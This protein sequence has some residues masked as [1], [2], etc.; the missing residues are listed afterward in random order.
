MSA[1]PGLVVTAPGSASISHQA[2]G[3]LIVREVTLRDFRSYPRLELALEPGVVLVSGLNG[4]G[5]TNLL[6]A[7]HVGT[8][9]FSPRSR[10]D[11]QLVR[12]DAS[13]GRVRLQGVNGET[14]FEAE[15]SLGPR[16]A[17]RARLN[18][19][20]LRSAEQLRHELQA[21]VFTPDRLA[22]VKGAPA[23]RRAYL[24]RTLGRF[25][26]ARAALPVEYAAAVGQRN[27]ALRRLAAGASSADA[28]PPW[29]ETVASLGA[30][31]VTARE[32][33]ITLLAPT[34]SRCADS[35]G[36]MGATL[37]YEGEPVTVSEYEQRL[38]RDLERGLTGAGPHLHEV[39]LEADGR[40]LRSYG[41]QGEQRIAVLALVLAEAETLTERS[42][43]RPLVL[44]DD[45]LSELDGDRRLALAALVS[46]AGQTVL[47]S[48][49]IAAY[50]MEPS[51]SLLVSPGEVRSAS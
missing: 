3:G 13:A 5:K 41:S 36:V 37:S 30:E 46:G 29:T 33:A 21:L 32:K 39:R 43:I 45:V 22:V 28:L 10:S 16:E 4:A 11:A 35:L 51:Q 23:V 7:L 18:G 24:D 12:F 25:F 49:A 8:Q 1:S 40:D 50:P 48:T 17:R 19:S 6:E 26:P 42:G 15:V 20:A 47:T 27:A 14:R 31:L 2:P 34:F 38:S 9:G 44:L